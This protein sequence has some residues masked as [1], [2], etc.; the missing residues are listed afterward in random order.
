[1]ISNTSTI[2]DQE[3]IFNYEILT[4]FNRHRITHIY[5]DKLDRVFN[6][7]RSMSHFKR[8]YKD[9]MLDIKSESK[10][11]YFCVGAEYT[12]LWKN[13]HTAKFRC[14]EVIDEENIKI[15]QLYFYD[16]E[17]NEFRYKVYYKFSRSTCDEYTYF[18]LDSVF[19]NLQA[20]SFYQIS[21]SSNDMKKL[22]K[23]ID[24][25]IIRNNEKHEQVESIILDISLSDLWKVIT[26]WK[27]FKKHVP[28]IADSI[29]YERSSDSRVS[30]IKLIYNNDDKEYYLK[31][32]KNELGE[33]SGDYQLNL[34]SSSKSFTKQRMHFKVVEMSGKCLLV[35]KHIYSKYISESVL[36]DLSENKK[37][38]LRMLKKSLK[39]V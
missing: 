31:V 18:Y 29:E 20:L 10:E 28:I 34:F 30:L 16:I 22:F 2:K 5:H 36:R 11:P 1:M 19:N 4:Q 9:F 23:H 6:L 3:P 26:D 35:F 39:I 17:P 32:L 7:Y 38:I 27:I 14:E 8:I 37:E 21:F 15:L 24:D 33:F 13:S 12:F 25:Y